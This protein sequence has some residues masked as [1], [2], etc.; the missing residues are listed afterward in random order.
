MSF[1]SS[2]TREQA[3]VTMLQ[4][5]SQS[6][7]NTSAIT[8][9]RFARTNSVTFEYAENETTDTVFPGEESVTGVDNSAGNDTE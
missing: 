2:G 8:R 5:R 1:D 9:V 7:S 4:Y 6:S 3:Q